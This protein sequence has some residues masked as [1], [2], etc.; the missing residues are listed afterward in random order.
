MPQAAPSQQQYQNT[1][2]AQL[3]RENCA[4]RAKL[5]KAKKER[6][7]TRTAMSQAATSLAHLQAEVQR[8]RTFVKAAGLDVQ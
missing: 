2:L 8:L 6:E 3:R 4:L 7:S 5:A 1:D